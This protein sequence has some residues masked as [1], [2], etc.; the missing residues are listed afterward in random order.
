M[1]ENI[2]FILPEDC[3]RNNLKTVKKMLRGTV[4]RSVESGDFPLED[5]KHE[6]GFYA[7]DGCNSAMLE[8]FYRVR[9]GNYQ[10]TEFDEVNFDACPIKKKR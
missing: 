2:T 9:N 4:K 1:I 3:L 10:K 6:L 8:I 5:G 7:C